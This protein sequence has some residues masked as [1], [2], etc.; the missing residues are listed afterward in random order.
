MIAVML[1]MAMAPSFYTTQARSVE[2]AEERYGKLDGYEMTA[3]NKAKYLVKFDPSQFGLNFNISMWVNRDIVLHLEQVLIELEEKQLLNQI[4]LT[5][6]CYSGRPVRGTD[7]PS[8]H[9]FGLACDFDNIEY[10]KEFVDVWKKYGW[11]WGGD[12]DGDKYDPMHFSY[13]WEC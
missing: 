6:G 8:T 10:S 2:E 12:W 4:T 5:Y 7:R 3:E 11:C 13:A 1:A 9:A